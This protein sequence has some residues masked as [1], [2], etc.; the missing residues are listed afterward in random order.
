MTALSSANLPSFD[1]P[2]VS[3]VA[4]SVQFDK[5]AGLR[6]F[7][8]SSL[9][10]LFSASFPR[11]EEHPP[12]DPRVELLK[13]GPEVRRIEFSLMNLPVVSRYF[14]ISKDGNE[15]IQ[16]QQ[17]QFG[18]N[19]RK[20]GEGDEYPRYERIRSQFKSNLETFCEFVAKERIGRFSPTQVEITYMNQIL[21][22]DG[23]EKLNE[24]D[25]V[26]NVQALQYSDNF[27]SQPEGI[28]HTERHLINETDGKSIGRLHITV[29]P[30]FR[31]AD[32]KAVLNL[33]LVARGYPATG[34]LDGVLRF[35]DIGREYIVRGF[36]S[37]TRPRMHDIWGRTK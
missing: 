11:V 21:S 28:S 31:I 30:G 26:L 25:S 32:G 23:W 7:Q 14:F 37:V 16:I 34:D 9:W 33:S 17:D 8:I 2:P 22:G 35:L 20:T 3:E 4:L 15:L 6:S 12:L 24:V 18:H 27:L 36:A 1:R 5:I 13:A 10:N 19:W 29:E